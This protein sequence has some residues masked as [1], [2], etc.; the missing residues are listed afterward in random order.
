MRRF[1]VEPSN[2]RNTEAIIVG[3]ESHHIS[4]VLRMNRGDKISLFDGHGNIFEA[5]IQ[6]ITREKTKASITQHERAVI[7]P[8]YLHL[9][10]ALLKGSKMDLI[11]QK[12][13]ELGIHTLYPF[14]SQ[15]SDAHKKKIKMDR[16][17]R[18]IFESCKQCQQPIP[19]VLKPVQ[20][21]NELLSI[22]EKKDKKIIFWEKEKAVDLKDVAFASEDNNQAV[23]IIIGP[24]GGFSDE[25][26]ELAQSAGFH[27]V[28]LGKRLLRAETA[29]IAAMSILQFQLGNL[30]KKI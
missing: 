22:P 19:P 29:A 9:G 1:F 26:I 20:N 7:E 2:I 14:T 5:I 30:D 8:P 16:W 23:F 24:E 13:T 10:F 12:A 21:F 11:I 6:E 28:T 3:Q 17:K 25:E 15:Y 4:K 27:S 18:I